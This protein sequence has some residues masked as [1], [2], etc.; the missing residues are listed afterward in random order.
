MD[1]MIVGPSWAAGGGALSVALLKT[2]DWWLARRRTSAAETGAAVLV[3]GLTKRVLDLEQR[4]GAMDSRLSEEIAR[5]QAAEEE[6]HALR[7]RI[8]TLETLITQHGLVV[9]ATR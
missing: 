3:E 7:L 1:D 8:L 2:Y 5:R 9:P 4:L 6:T